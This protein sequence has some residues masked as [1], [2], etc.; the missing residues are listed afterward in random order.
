MKE[1]LLQLQTLL[2]DINKQ[3]ENYNILKD[4]TIQQIENIY[5]DW[6]DEIFL[7]QM[8]GREE[9]Y[10]RMKQLTISD[11]LA[12]KNDETSFKL[13]IQQLK[14]IL[15]EFL[16][17]LDNNVHVDE[18]SLIIQKLIENNLLSYDTK[19]YGEFKNKNY[20]GQFTR[21][22]HFEVFG[23]DLA[24]KFPSLTKATEAICG[25]ADKRWNFWCAY[26]K[27]G[28]KQNLGYFRSEFLKTIK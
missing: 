23:H 21:D 5:S 4:L 3:V 8:R 6:E 2:R 11:M 22:N 15:T 7:E 20:T 9:E 14:E 13:D 18:D 16:S 28:R 10:K 17:K 12:R 26:D 25:K 1:K 27:I 24:Q 19:I